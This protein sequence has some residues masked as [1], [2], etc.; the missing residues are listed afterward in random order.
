[1]FTELL[2]Q[3]GSADDII[4]MKNGFV[5]DCSFGN[6]VFRKGDEYY[7]PA[8]FLLNG[9]RRQQLLSQGLVSEKEFTKETIYT[10]D[11]CIII[12]AMLGLRDGAEVDVSCIS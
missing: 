3:K 2:Q 4:I 11:T 8:N 10:M 5:T 1:M 9:T 6:L 7:T 12:N